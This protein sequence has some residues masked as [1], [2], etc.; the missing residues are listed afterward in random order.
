MDDAVQKHFAELRA[1]SEAYRRRHAGALPA[2]PDLPPM[3][4]FAE[5]FPEQH[6]KNGERHGIKQAY[7]EPKGGEE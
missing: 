6:R 3:G 4:S 1:H 7:R 5:D 2:N